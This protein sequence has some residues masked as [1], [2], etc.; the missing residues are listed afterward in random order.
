MNS[1]WPYD[2]PVMG[3]CSIFCRS[4][5]KSAVY[6]PLGTV[7]I[8]RFCILMQILSLNSEESIYSNYYII[9]GTHDPKKRKVLQQNAM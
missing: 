9:K 3:V 6:I 1:L 4:G 2:Y 7:N 8:M 5:S